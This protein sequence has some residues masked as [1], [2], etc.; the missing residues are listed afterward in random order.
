MEDP[1]IPELTDMTEAK[2]AVK[3]KVRLWIQEVYRYGDRCAA[4]EEN[5]GALYTVLMDGVLKTIKSNMKRKTG[6]KK[7]DEVNDSVW[8]LE[9]LEDIMINLEDV[10]PRK[11]AIDDHTERI[12]K[13]KQG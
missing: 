7:A 3:W 9:T 6:Y 8:L 11:L 2:E 12:M 1:K 10:K 4:L 13:R 5:K